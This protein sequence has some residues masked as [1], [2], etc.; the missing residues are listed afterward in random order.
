[1]LE[2]ILD[3]TF[4]CRAR[5]QVIHSVLEIECHTTIVSKR[6]SDHE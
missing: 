1:M 4:F 5:T 6:T 3:I 2:V